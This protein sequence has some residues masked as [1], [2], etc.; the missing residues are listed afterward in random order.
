MNLPTGWSL[1]THDDGTQVAYKRYTGRERLL[2][3]RWQQRHLEALGAGEDLV[4][5][6]TAEVEQ[7]SLALAER[8][9]YWPSGEP[10]TYQT[11]LEM[12]GTDVER[13][14]WLSHLCFG[15]AWS[16]QQSEWSGAKK[17]YSRLLHVH[18]RIHH[19][20]R[21]LAGIASDTST[22]NGIPSEDDSGVSFVPTDSLAELA[23]LC[24]NTP[25]SGS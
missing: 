19:L 6:A 21:E 20:L 7:E 14:K 22:K 11:L 9:V 18:A 1:A 10:L 24:S 4:D 12:N 5:C 25:E 8:V 17:N 13:W 3:V 23:T 2:V 15:P 16:D